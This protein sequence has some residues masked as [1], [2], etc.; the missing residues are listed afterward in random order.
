MLEH[1][2]SGSAICIPNVHSGTTVCQDRPFGFQ[3]SILAPPCVR[4]GHL[5]SKYPFWHHGASGSAICI[6]NI[7]SGTTV[8]P[9]QPSGLQK[10]ILA[11]RCVRIS[12]LRSKYPFR[13]HGVSESAIWIPNIHFGTTVVHTCLLIHWG[14]A[15]WPF[16]NPQGDT[17]HEI[18][19]PCISSHHGSPKQG[20][21]HT[22]C[23]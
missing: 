17:S 1:G 4:I 15:T 21:G 10:S 20:H 13:Y 2:V 16:P 18:P 22:D 19:C 3:M 11:P 14:S 8:C 9:D 7:H 12:H 5:H 6:P 23:T